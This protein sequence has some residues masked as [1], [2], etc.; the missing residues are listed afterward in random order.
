[1][2][3][4][5]ILAPT[6]GFQRSVSVLYDLDDRE[7]IR[8]FIPTDH[9]E[10]VM[11][12]VLDA[13]AGQG[14]R[15]L[16][17]IGSYGTGKSH[18]ATFIGSLLG[19]R[20]ATCDFEAVLTRVRDKNLRDALTREVNE[21]RPYLIVPAM[22]GTYDV[23]TS[24]LKALRRAVER[25]QLKLTLD[26]AFARAVEVVKRWET[27]YKETYLRFE[28][29]LRATTFISVDAFLRAL[30]NADKDALRWFEFLYRKLS[31]GAEFDQYGSDV[32]ETYVQV[33]RNLPALNYRGIFVVFDEFNRVL[34]EGSRDALT[35][36]TLQDLAEACNRSNKDQNI[37]LMLISHKTIGQY[38]T[39][40]SNNHAEEWLKVEGR[41]RI[42]DLTRHPGERYQLMGKVLTK[43]R[44]DW[45]EVL[46]SAG[47]ALLCADNPRLRDLLRLRLPNYTLDAI[48]ALVKDCFPLHPVLVYVLPLVSNRLAQNERT[49]FTFMASLDE[50]PLVRMLKREL[51]DVEYIYL[52]QL[53]DYFET[54]MRRSS[55]QDIGTTWIKV[56]NALHQFDRDGSEGMILRTIG[57]LS[58]LGNQELTTREVVEFSL[59]PKLSED[60]FRGAL[61]RLIEK[62]LVFM[63]DT[64]SLAIAVPVGMD[65]NAELAARVHRMTLESVF[66]LQKYGIRDYVVPQRFNLE[67]GMTRYLSPRYVDY[68]GLLSTLQEASTGLSPGVD[69]LIVYVFPSSEQDLAD[70][71]RV[72]LDTS[73]SQLVLVCLPSK[74]VLIRDAVLKVRALDDIRNS[75]RKTRLDEDL[76]H[77][78]AMYFDD[79]LSHLRRI[80]SKL[81]VPS[82]FVEYYWKGQKREAINSP[83]DLSDF[84]SDMMRRV[85]EYTPVINNELV[86][87]ANPTSTSRRALSFVIDAVLRGTARVGAK[88]RSSQE[89]F[90]F[91]TLFVLTGLHPSS[92]KPRSESCSRILQEVESFLRQTYGKPATMEQLITNLVQPPYGIRAGTIPVFLAAALSEHAK[93]VVFRDKSGAECLLTSALLEKITGNPENYSVEVEK[94]NDYYDLLVLGLADVFEVDL[95]MASHSEFEMIGDA[96]FRWFV[97][98]PKVARE[99][100]RVDHVAQGLRRV[101]RRIIR[102]PREVILREIPEIS[103]SSATSR[104]GVRRILDAVSRAKV[105][106]ENVLNVERAVVTRLTEDLLR[107][108]GARKGSILQMSKEFLNMHVS[109]LGMSRDFDRFADCIQSHEGSDIEFIEDLAHELIG[110]PLADWTDETEESFRSILENILATA[111]NIETHSEEPQVEISFPGPNNSPPKKYF[112]ARGPVSELAAL[113]QSELEMAI[114]DF[115]DAISRTEVKQVLLGILERMLAP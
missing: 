40:N 63:G 15:A 75:V 4:E 104:D 108:C 61:L 82:S 43:L 92:D 20:V 74:P 23:R 1:M 25:E 21:S 62:R 64:E 31:A 3:L 32:V 94:W 7:R 71:R 51:S 12:H 57:I 81:T 98:L 103:G 68:R 77:V 111:S 85:Y 90:M 58:I 84:V 70:C 8:G 79:A 9:A 36:K 11:S 67:T 107:K 100:K 26:S 87:R 46:E 35:L 89:Q 54:E 5:E 42:Y 48:D 97:S 6:L 102:N 16:M 112:I 28:N 33:A 14:N 114:N 55:E 105:D 73:I 65:I 76:E 93:T 13:L 95:N 24:L 72:V 52:Y 53:F 83:V 86:N 69:G 34:E 60:E 96:V 30:D 29:E 101:A 47:K 27:E 17:I 49:M 39:G 38:V 78:L 66:D 44:G 50:S 45:Q 109:R 18:L 113:L 19:K 80:V 56:A 91:D 59:R 110:I 10:W 106:L 99:T 115:G 37:Y 88:M 2:K 22:G 41:F